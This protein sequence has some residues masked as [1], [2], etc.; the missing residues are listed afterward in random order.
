M[1][2]IDGRLKVTGR[3]PYAY[4]QKV[5]NAVY[6][7]L[8]MSTIAKGKIAS[9]DGQ[10]AG[11]STGVLLVITPENSLKLPQLQNQPKGGWEVQVLQDNVVR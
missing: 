6:A 1:D 5:P 10:A 7:V 11:R 2:R 8:V 4:E 3:A 9:I